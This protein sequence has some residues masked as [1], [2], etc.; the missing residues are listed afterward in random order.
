M[1][2]ALQLLTPILLLFPA[3][4]VVEVPREAVLP[5]SPAAVPEQDQVSVNQRVTVRISTRPAPMPMDPAALDPERGSR[6]YERKMGKCLPLAD[7]A[8]IQPVSDSRLLFILRDD[9]LVSVQ[10]QK[11]CQAREFYSGL[12]VKRPED[13]QL[14]VKRDAL[15][16]RSGASCQVSS[17][18]QLVPIGN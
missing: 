4:A 11:G 14:C 2:P 3:M 8:G 18:R 12:I 10:L 7:I 17:F 16:S 5:A 13:G 6:F 1:N 15:L 9:R